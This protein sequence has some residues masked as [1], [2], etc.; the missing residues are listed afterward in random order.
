MPMRFPCSHLW[1]RCKPP[2]AS[3]EA[4]ELSGTFHEREASREPLLRTVSQG[5]DVGQAIASRV[6]ARTRETAA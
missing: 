6:G 5:I 4:R 3:A 2:W 1:A